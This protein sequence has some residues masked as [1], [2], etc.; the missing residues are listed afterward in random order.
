MRCIFFS[1]FNWHF[2][3]IASPI[4]TGGYNIEDYYITDDVTLSDAIDYANEI[5][6]F[7]VISSY[8]DEQD[9]TPKQQC[10]KK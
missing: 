3:I 4:S 5:Y 6:D 9:L 2:I 8:I 1:N 10:S 7:E